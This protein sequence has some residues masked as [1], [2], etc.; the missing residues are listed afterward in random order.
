M[1]FFSFVAIAIIAFVV[2]GPEAKKKTGKKL[3]TDKP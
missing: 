3:I 1:K 2:A